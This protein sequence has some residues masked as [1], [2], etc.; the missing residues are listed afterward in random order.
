MKKSYITP[1]LNLFSV[2]T[3]AGIAFSEGINDGWGYPGEDPN[4]NDYGEF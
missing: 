3:E 2:E 4:V 1:E